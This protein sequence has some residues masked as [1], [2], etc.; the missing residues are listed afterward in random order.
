MNNL[1]SNQP[2]IQMA[3]FPL[4]FSHGNVRLNKHWHGENLKLSLVSPWAYC[5]RVAIHTWWGNHFLKAWNKNGVQKEPT[6]NRK[7]YFVSLFYEGKT[8][9][10]SGKEKNI[11][12]IRCSLNDTKQSSTNWRQKE[13]MGKVWTSSKSLFWKCPSLS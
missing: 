1:L 10:E 13:T 12:W 7:F 3:I 4:I 6:T 5:S 2:K 9:F 8:L 11:G